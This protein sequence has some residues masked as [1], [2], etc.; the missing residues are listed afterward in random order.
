[1]RLIKFMG[2]RISY[3]QFHNPSFSQCVPLGG[4]EITTSNDRINMSRAPIQTDNEGGE[5]S[6]T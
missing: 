6:E 1:M 3:S 2:M 5:D 4:M